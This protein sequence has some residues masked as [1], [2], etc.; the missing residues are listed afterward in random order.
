[1]I[2]QPQR[3][4]S[5]AGGVIL[6]RPR[7]S[8]QSAGSLVYQW[9]ANSLLPAGPGSS[10]FSPSDFLGLGL[11]SLSGGQLGTPL[12][13]QKPVAACSGIVTSAEL[14][15]RIRDTDWPNRAAIAY[16]NRSWVSSSR[17]E[18]KGRKS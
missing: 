11:A 3:K 15:E 13:T 10:D 9:F 17:M 12:E 4:S 2:L 7:S 8:A 18:R 16:T 14:M 1:M 6:N 5:P